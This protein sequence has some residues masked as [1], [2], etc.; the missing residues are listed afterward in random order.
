MSKRDR[1]NT[2]LLINISVSL[3]V[4]NI[5]A[6]SSTSLSR[7][8]KDVCR[9]LIDEVTEKTNTLSE[10]SKKLDKETS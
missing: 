4:A 10:R 5:L 3:G 7:A 6:L 8:E 1:L 2:D 9:A